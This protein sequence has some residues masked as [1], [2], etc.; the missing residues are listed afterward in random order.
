M[1][2]RAGV[3]PANHSTTGRLPET[4]ADGTEYSRALERKAIR[5]ICEVAA[6]AG[7]PI[8]RSVARNQVREWLA[9]GVDVETVL[10]GHLGKGGIK[11]DTGEKATHQADAAR[12]RRAGCP[13][14]C[15]APDECRAGSVRIGPGYCACSACDLDQL[16]RGI[17][18]PAHTIGAAR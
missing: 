6:S 13:C 4:K 18:C 17:G 10:H 1:D 11:D 9:S 7:R 12:R 3:S 2:S 14:G 8:R 16:A 15:S 5:A